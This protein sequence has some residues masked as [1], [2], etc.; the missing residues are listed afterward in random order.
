MIVKHRPIQKTVGDKPQHHHRQHQHRENGEQHGFAVFQPLFAAA[1]EI[2]DEILKD[3][4]GLDTDHGKENLNRHSQ[5]KRQSHIPVD[6][7]L[8][9]AALEQY[10]KPVANHDHSHE[11]AVPDAADIM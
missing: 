11:P 7:P 2:T 3:I 4:T 1:E 9:A 10:G 5:Q 6:V 8:Y